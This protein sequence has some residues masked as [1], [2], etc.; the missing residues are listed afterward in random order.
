MHKDKN[1]IYMQHSTITLLIYSCSLN[2]P[3]KKKKSSEFRREILNMKQFE[4]V[5]K[6]RKLCIP[7]MLILFHC[8][9]LSLCVCARTCVHAYVYACTQYTKFKTIFVFALAPPTCSM[10]HTTPLYDQ[11]QPSALNQFYTLNL[12]ND[13]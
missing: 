12:P 2:F 4:I 8:N 5:L 3:M 10:V 6:Y 7:L 13:L 1:K 11:M 9:I